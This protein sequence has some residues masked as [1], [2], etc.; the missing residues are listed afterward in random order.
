MNITNILEHIRFSE[1]KMQKVPIFESEKM[2]FDLYCLQPGQFQ[3][4]HEHAGEDKVYL[5]LQGNATVTLGETEHPLQENES[6]IARAGVAHG[7][8]NDTAE[9]LVLLVTMSPRPGKV[10]K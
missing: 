6:A 2:F 9:N 3:K 10:K 4:V 7:V 1:E 8:R 5:V